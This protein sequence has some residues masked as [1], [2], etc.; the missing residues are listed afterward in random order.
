VRIV[1][2]EFMDEVA[3]ASL[4]RRFDVLHDAGL[5][6][7]RSDLLAVLEGADALIVRNRT[8]VDAALLG[9]APRLRVVG[10]LGVGLDNIDMQACEARRIEVIPARGANALAVAEYVIGAAIVLLRGAY[11]ASEV[12]ASGEWPRTALGTGREVAGK[13]IGVVGFGSIGQLVG[14]LARALGMTVIGFDV[15][16]PASSGLWAEQHATPRRF[17]D[18]LRDADVVSLHVPLT[19]ATRHLIDA[20]KL[21]LMKREAILINTSRGGV[22]DEAA[23]AA[24]LKAGKVAGAALDVFEMEPLP[25]ASPLVG[26]PGLILTPHIAGVTRESNVRVSTMIADK[27]AAALDEQR[28]G[29]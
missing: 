29:P 28:A 1:I 12:V 7:R 23:L 5:V 25:A 3:V 17:D 2:P 14:R 21:E 20:G 19:P 27:V 9:V 26:C 6:E 24:A 11:F 8:Q 15:E 22:V 18:L 10:R 13:T 16:I 4:R